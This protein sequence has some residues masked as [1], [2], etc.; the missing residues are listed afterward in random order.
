MRLIDLITLP[1]AA[2]WQQKLRTLL[3]TLGVVFGAFVLAASLSI[4]Q[5]VEET[6]NRESHR[7][8]VSRRIE[9][10]PMYHSMSAVVGTKG[11]KV[12][13]TMSDERRNRLRDSIADGKPGSNPMRVR[14]DLT[15]ER[16]NKLAAIPNVR[17]LVPLV[18]NSGIATFGNKS[19]S[20]Q[21]LSARPDDAACRRRIVAGRFF[22]TSDEHAVVISEF[23][24]YRLGLVNDAD[25]EALIGKPLRIG[26]RARKMDS[27]LSKL[28]GNI[29]RDQRTVVDQVMARVPGVLGVLGLTNQQ[30]AAARRGVP[31]GRGPAV[32]PEVVQKDFTV[33]GVIRK[34]REEERHGPRDPL[35]VESD[36]ILPYQTALDLYFDG[37]G[38]EQPGVSLAVLHVNSEKDVRNVVTRVAEMG[39]E[40]KAALE[41]IERDRVI[42]TLVFGGMT[43]VA[44]VALLVSALGIANTMLM[45][46]LER[47]RE[48][49]IMKAV[50]ADNKQLQFIFLVEGA[51]IGLFGGII[52]VLLAWALPILETPGSVP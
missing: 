32:V 11:V 17:S 20:V 23:L 37:V 10:L 12:D 38:N 7:N 36:V 34:L 22:N 43:S 16:M 48:I 21:V 13:G 27:G 45:S 8:E 47:T 46:V 52:G 35:R 30:A 50:G 9:V 4:G 25:V 49:G 2:L 31:G 14:V 42:Y 40:P 51:V 15:R 18:H 26:F 19:Q 39:F 33:V 6:I 28:L 1:I 29:S 3:T 44:G 5:G 24:A 41:W